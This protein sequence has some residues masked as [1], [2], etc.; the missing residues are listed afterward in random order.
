M[1]LPTQVDDLTAEWLT[2]ALERQHPGTEVQAVAVAG[3]GYQLEARFY[4]DIAP[5]LETATPA[6]WYAE[7]DA[8]RIRAS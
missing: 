8:S 2:G 6:C 3:L 5:Q 7:V 1:S 4:R